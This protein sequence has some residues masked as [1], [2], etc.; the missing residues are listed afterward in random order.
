MV[1]RV[2]GRGYGEEIVGGGYGK[3]I[4]HFGR[5]HSFVDCVLK[6]TP[7]N[8]MRDINDKSPN[9]QPHGRELGVRIMQ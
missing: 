8:F 9:V 2:W 6:L 7:P 5:N 3:K 4:L 1:S